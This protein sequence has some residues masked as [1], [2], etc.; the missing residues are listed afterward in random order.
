MRTAT[1]VQ[2][3]NS[4]MDGVTPPSGKAEMYDDET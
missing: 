1:E 2:K 4:T 3:K